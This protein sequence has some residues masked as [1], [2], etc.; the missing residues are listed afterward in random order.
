MYNC[1]LP[2]F[3]VK[4]YEC[5]DNCIHTKQGQ[6]YEA[7]GSDHWQSALVLINLIRPRNV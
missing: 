2:P 3:W 7:I 4:S 5:C 6:W 1:L